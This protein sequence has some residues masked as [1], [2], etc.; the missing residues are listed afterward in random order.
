MTDVLAPRLLAWGM[1]SSG[2][3]LGLLVASFVGE[4]APVLLLWGA[5]LL[6]VGVALSAAHY[7]LRKRVNGR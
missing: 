1:T 6:G 5:V 3:G 7:F 4:D 2:L